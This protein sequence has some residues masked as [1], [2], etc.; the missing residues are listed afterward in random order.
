MAC[1]KINEYVAYARN[2]ECGC[3]VGRYGSILL[4]I[5]LA[6]ILQSTLSKVIGRQFC[7]SSNEPSSFGIRVIIPLRCDV[8][9]S[10]TS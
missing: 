4:V 3:K 1:R 6:A 9:S 8:E 5:A 7:N 10:F 2:T